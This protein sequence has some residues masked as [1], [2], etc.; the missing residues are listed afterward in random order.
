[1]TLKDK[2][3]E[4][5]PWKI[6]P[7]GSTKF[8]YDDNVFL[9]SDNEKE[10][11][12]TTISPGIRVELPFNYEKSIFQLDYTADII[13]YSDYTD[14]SDE[15]HK[16]SALLDT[17]FGDYSLTLKNVFR[18]FSDIANTEFTQRVPREKNVA[19]V[20]FGAN[21]NRIRTEIMY[22]NMDED[23]RDFD[24]LD[25]TDN[26]LTLTGYTRIL[27]KTDALLEYRYADIS[28]DAAGSTRDGEYNQFC[29]GL[30]GELAQKVSALIKAGYQNR[31]YDSAGKNSWKEPVVYAGLTYN[32]SE[33]TLFNLSVERTA[34]ESTY[35]SNNFYETN[36]SSM[37]ISHKF[38]YKLTGK[39]GAFLQENK[40]PEI[41]TE[42]TE[43]KKR[44]DDLHG[45]NIGLKYDIQK[46]LAAE[47]EYKN[48]KRDSNFKDFDYN[49]NKVLLSISASF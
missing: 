40:Y 25:R 23:Y 42:G 35:S 5:G 28:Y 12:I 24:E 39:V 36:K 26:V 38:G 19:S 9:E 1:E 44:D 15:Q 45:F 22:E 11:F 29:A 47:L 3:L 20:K 33:P 30:K 6:H 32:I 7:Y 18:D 34:E 16:I 41:T 8:E 10:D 21:F 14:Q 4:I 43:S 37:E 13:C 48:S 17:K 31:D 27:P 2:N 49:D 46:W